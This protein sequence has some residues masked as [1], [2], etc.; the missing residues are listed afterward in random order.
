MTVKYEGP[1]TGSPKEEEAHAFDRIGGAERPDRT[2]ETPEEALLRRRIQENRCQRN[3]WLKTR[4]RYRLR[5]LVIAVGGVLVLAAA[6]FGLRALWDAAPEL[7]PPNGGVD[8]SHITYPD[9]IEQ[10]FIENPE[11]RTREPLPAVRDLAIHYVGNPGSSAKGNR[12]YF[13]SEGVEV[14]SHFIVGLDGEVLQCLPL[15]ERSV[16]T[17]QRNGDTISI[18][19]C[20]PDE[21]GQFSEVTY[22]SLIRLTAWL[23]EQ[24]DLSEENLIRH[25]DVSGKLCPLYY[26]QH[27]EAW[28]QLKRDVGEALRPE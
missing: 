24:F 10:V 28:L 18:E 16:A 12:N 26:V 15:N 22:A 11:A 21:T 20:H 9:W 27:E 1:E 19:V 17:N 4:R 13:N 14:C 23:C 8:I 5:I 7:S 6:F 2:S 3:E 25:Y